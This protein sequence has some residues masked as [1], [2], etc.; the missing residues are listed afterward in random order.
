MRINTPVS[1]II[2]CVCVCVWV[3]RNLSVTV[4]TQGMFLTIWISFTPRISTDQV[5]EILK[6]VR[7]CRFILA[8]IP[9]I[10][11]IRIAAIPQDG[12]ISLS[13]I[14]KPR[15]REW[16]ICL[17]SVCYYCCGIVVISEQQSHFFH[18]ALWY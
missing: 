3:C 16:I 4:E 7:H 14:L 1:L 2:M 9:G 5:S 15:L 11:D 10:S 8:L 13:L 18:H 12:V 6:K 17:N